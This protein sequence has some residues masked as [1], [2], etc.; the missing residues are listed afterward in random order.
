[1]LGLNGSIDGTAQTLFF[2]PRWTQINTDL[3]LDSLGPEVGG[4]AAGAWF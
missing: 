3:V 2:S 1:M 4:L